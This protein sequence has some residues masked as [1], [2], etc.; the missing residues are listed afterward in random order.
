MEGNKSGESGAFLFS[1]R[2]PDFC[3][4]RRSFPISENPKFVIRG[5]RRWISLITTPLNSWAP[6]S[7]SQIKVASLENTSDSYFE[8]LAQEAKKNDMAFMDIII[9]G[10]PG[11]VSR[12]GI[13]GAA[14][15]FKHGL[16]SPWVPTLTAPFPNGQENAGS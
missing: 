16:K 8:S 1:L 9:L 3:D 13:K 7:L 15:V 5:R 12:A 10:D 11:A 14:K 6:V 4:V 2:V